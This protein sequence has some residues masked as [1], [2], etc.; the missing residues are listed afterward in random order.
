MA[1]SDNSL[2]VL[3]LEAGALGAVCKELLAIRKQAK[4]I[5]IQQVRV[6]PHPDFGRP[7]YGYP[8]PNLPAEVDLRFWLT[9]DV[10]NVEQALAALMQRPSD[11]EEQLK[12]QVKLLEKDNTAL[13]NT[14]ETV[15]RAND[16]RAQRTEELID[17]LTEIGC[18]VERAIG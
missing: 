4:A 6:T 1:V 3:T 8:V 18:R 11:K 2:E 12:A 13:R 15:R 10:K 5:G 17:V 14:L 16:E 9:G 7:Y